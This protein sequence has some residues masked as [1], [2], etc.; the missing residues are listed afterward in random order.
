MESLAIFA[1]KLHTIEGYEEWSAMYR[2]LL[3]QLQPQSSIEYFL[4]VFRESD[5]R[6]SVVGEY[7]LPYLYSMLRSGYQN[8]AA[9]EL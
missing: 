7:L 3:G 9:S 6:I 4:V 5:D 1:S 2:E 8:L